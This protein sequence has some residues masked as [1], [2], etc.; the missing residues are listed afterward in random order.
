MAPRVAALAAARTPLFLRAG[1]LDAGSAE[2]VLM[3]FGRLPN[4]MDIV[5]GHWTHGFDADAD[6]EVV[7]MARRDVERLGEL[8]KRSV[9]R[10]GARPDR[11]LRVRE[12]L[13]DGIRQQ[14]GRRV[15]DHFQAICILG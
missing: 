6:P 13:L 9:A 11:D 4:D 14:V 8:A 5:I 2:G 7:K 15:A 3:R 12:Q 10:R 1:W